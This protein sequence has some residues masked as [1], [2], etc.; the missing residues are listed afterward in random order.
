MFFRI[1]CENQWKS[2]FFQQ[3][4]LLFEFG[5]SPSMKTQESVDK[6]FQ[7]RVCTATLQFYGQM[8]QSS[9]QILCFPFDFSQKILVGI[10]WFFKQRMSLPLTSLTPW[11]CLDL[12]HDSTPHESTPHDSTPYDSTPHEPTPHEPNVTLW[13]YP[14]WVYPSWVHPSWVY[15]PWVYLSRLY[16]SWIYPSLAH[17]SWADP[18]LSIGSGVASTQKMRSFLELSEM[19]LN[20]LKCGGWLSEM[21][22]NCLK[23]G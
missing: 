2:S 3:R 7:F 20:C 19:R 12:P 6:P 21:Q 9:P 15:P 17:S 1:I 11:A 10:Q 22:L 16:P 14:S 13:V 18:R 8:D 4:T 5:S 23:C